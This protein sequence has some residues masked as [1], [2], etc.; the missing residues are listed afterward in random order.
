MIPNPIIPTKQNPI[1]I[2]KVVEYLKPFLLGVEY[3][4]Q[5]IEIIDNIET[6][7]EKK[8]K[9]YE[10]NQLF[11]IAEIGELSKEPVIKKQKFDYHSLIPNDNKKSVCFLYE[12]DER[13]IDNNIVTFDISLL[14][15]FNHSL[16]IPNTII[17]QVHTELFLYKTI[18]ALKKGIDYYNQKFSIYK[19]KRNVFEDFKLSTEKSHLKYPIDGFRIRFKLTLRIECLPNYFLTECL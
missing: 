2:D 3:D 1:G 16:L 10:A 9:F 18:N 15:T 8:L 7:V 5:A 14:T 17:E 6:C 13:M 12:H 11:G 19:D 4:Y